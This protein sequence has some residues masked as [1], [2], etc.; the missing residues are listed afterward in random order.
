[1]GVTFK[2]QNLLKQT[3]IQTFCFGRPL[4]SHLAKMYVAIVSFLE[5]AMNNT[6]LHSSGQEIHISCSQQ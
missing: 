1:M 2:E 5:T 3:V 4:K 6:E